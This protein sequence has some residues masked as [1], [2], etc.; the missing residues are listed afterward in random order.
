MDECYKECHFVKG[1]QL[2]ATRMTNVQDKLKQLALESER[3]E[4]HE[5]QISD[6]DKIPKLIDD[7][8]ES[9]ETMGYNPFKGM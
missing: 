9:I 6:Y 8:V 2:A 3:V 7:F 1:S 4:I 5:I